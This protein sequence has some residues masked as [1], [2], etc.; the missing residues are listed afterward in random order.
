MDHRLK[1]ML[2]TPAGSV[3][4]GPGWVLEG[5]LDG[6]RLVCHSPADGGDVRVYA[7]RNSSEY[8][9]Q[10]PYIETHLLYLLPPDT[11]VDGEIIGRHG[12]GDVQSVMSR[13]GG[14]H[15]P[16][17]GLPALTY[18]MFDTMR[19]AGEDVRPL[20][21][22]ERRALL[23]RIGPTDGLNVRV[24]PYVDAS[25]Q[26]HQAMLELGLEGSVCKYVD[27]RYVGHRS[28][29][30]VKIKPQQTA[31]AKVI[32]FKAGTAGTELD[33]LVG[34]LELEMLGSGARTRA[35]GM[36]DA[37]RRDMTDH[38]ERWLGQ[39]VEISYLA[40][41]ST[42]VPRSPN[43]LRRRDDRIANDAPVTPVKEV[44]VMAPSPRNYNA[45]KDEKLLRVKGELEDGGDAADRCLAKGFDPA[46]D[47]ER[48]KQI[49]ESR[50][51]L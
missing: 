21:W 36:S 20:P 28:P 7:G 37:E 25:E 31:E 34:A 42:G 2:C 49:A 47:L 14:P 18:V 40:L 10:L 48:V 46:D 1:P 24:A 50:G 15:V 39:I 27:S 26:A 9:G 17:A 35:S 3:P 4:A 19:W 32:G 22:R 5:K 29:M 38:P 6:W 11:V 41:G 45:M 44:R 12:W 30:W 51:L 8:S 16:T 43:Y 13:G 23:E 33:G